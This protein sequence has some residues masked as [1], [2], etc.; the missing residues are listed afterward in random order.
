MEEETMT[1]DDIRNDIEEINY[2]EVK[3]KLRNLIEEDDY[4]DFIR[5]LAE[6]EGGTPED[7]IIEIF[8]EMIEHRKECF[9]P[10]DEE[11]MVFS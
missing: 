7:K 4:A 5:T 6:E 10:A 1:L 3:N 2:E 11:E 9:E 8:E